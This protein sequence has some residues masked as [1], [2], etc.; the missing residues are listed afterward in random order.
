MCIY[1]YLCMYVCMHAC[2]Y[3]CMHVCMYV[4]VKTR[5]LDPRVVTMLVTSEIH[6]AGKPS[7]HPAMSQIPSTPQLLFKAP[8][9]PSNRDHAAL[10]RGT[11]GV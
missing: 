9:I 10:N 8:Q 1:T 4:Q 7:Q 3:V 11:L 5:R 6:S 2:M